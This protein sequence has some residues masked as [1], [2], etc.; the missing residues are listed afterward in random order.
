MFTALTPWASPDSTKAVYY[1]Y[2]SLRI[3]AILL[4]PVIPSKASEL[5]DRLGVEQDQRALV[6][7]AWENGKD[8]DIESIVAGLTRGK[9]GG[10]LFPQ[11]IKQEK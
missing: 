1:A 3:S 9:K 7:A 11:V 6:H 5:L 4:Q 2:H 8:A 10:Y